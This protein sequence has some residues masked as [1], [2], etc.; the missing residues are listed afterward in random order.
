MNN[1]PANDE[2]LTR[3]ENLSAEVV[4]EKV[5]Q[6]FGAEFADSIR[7]L[8]AEYIKKNFLQFFS[9]KAI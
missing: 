2:R 5:I 4:K 3:I 6:M 8:P 7:E 9:K 1:L